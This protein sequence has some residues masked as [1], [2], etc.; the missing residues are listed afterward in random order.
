MFGIAEFTAIIN[1]PQAAILAV[2]GGRQ[3]IN[4]DTMRPETVMTSTLSFDRR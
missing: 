4:P 2:G 3:I 1:A